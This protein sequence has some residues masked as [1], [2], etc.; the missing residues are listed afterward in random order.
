V[1]Y[2]EGLPTGRLPGRLVRGTRPDI[3]LR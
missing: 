3:E 2:R 1:T